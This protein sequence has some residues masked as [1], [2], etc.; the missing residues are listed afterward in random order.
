MRPFWLSTVTA[1]LVW[2]AA[3]SAE[4]A[5]VI[6]EFSGV[7]TQVPAIVAGAYQV[8]DAISGRYTVHSDAA[9]LDASSSVGSYILSVENFQAK[10][11]SY[12]LTGAFR[13][14]L[15]VVNGS[16]SDSYSIYSV[17]NGPAAA[18]PTP[19]L[20]GIELM[21]GAESVFASDAI[22]AVVNP[23][24]FAK[25]E[26]HLDFSTMTDFGRLVGRVDKISIVPEPSGLSELVVALGACLIRRRTR[27]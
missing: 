20:A 27:R 17:V 23:A 26:F 9:D 24:D 15:Q 6:Y 1:S 25:P 2:V 22:P 4:A 7:V 10:V 19:A 13:A 21:E 14:D 11:C 18:G 3:L 12:S 8:G 16:P 5:P